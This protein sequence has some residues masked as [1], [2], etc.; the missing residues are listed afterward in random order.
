MSEHCANIHWSREAATFKGGSYSRDHT[1]DFGSDQSVC[2]SAAAEYGGS[3]NC[4]DPEQALVAAIASCHMLT[5]LAIAAKKRFVVDRYEDHAVGTL[6]KDEEGHVC[7]EIVRLHPVIVFEGESG[8]T[9]EALETMHA[10]AHKHCIIANSV[11][12]RVV[13]GE[14]EEKAV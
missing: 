6:G 11:K 4:V 2:A 9:A 3:D 8:P 12:T 14:R 10:L 13:V 5:F 7:V 1:W